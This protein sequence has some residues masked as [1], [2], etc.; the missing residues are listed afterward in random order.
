[1]SAKRRDKRPGNFRSALHRKTQRGFRGYPIAT[2]AFYGP[3][4]Q[5]ATKIAVG[6]VTGQD[7]MVALERWYSEGRDIRKDEA[8]AREVLAF[9][10]RHEVKSVVSVDRIIGCPHEEG[11]DYPLGESCPECPFWAHRDRWTGELMH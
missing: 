5:V 10:K 6:I 9:I 1:M 2:L 11:K 8:V 7:E 3:D 4:D